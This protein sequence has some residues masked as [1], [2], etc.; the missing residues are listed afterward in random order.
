MRTAFALVVSELTEGTGS[1]PTES[2]KTIVL[3]LVEYRKIHRLCYGIITGKA[4]AALRSCVSVPPMVAVGAALMSVVPSMRTAL[5][6]RF[7]NP[8]RER[9]P[10]PSREKHCTT[11]CSIAKD[12]RALLQETNRQDGCR[13]R[14]ALLCVRSSDGCR[15]RFWN[16]RSERNRSQ[17]GTERQRWKAPAFVVPELTEGTESQPTKNRNRQRR[18]N[19]CSTT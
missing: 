13:C 10:Q 1:Q 8:Q 2:R 18:Q 19:H 12:P 5:P 15:C 7:W 9:K 11:T 4:V 14:L 17:R 3:Q 6:C 16:P